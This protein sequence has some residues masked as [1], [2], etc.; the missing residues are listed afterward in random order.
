MINIC[1]QWIILQWLHFGKMYPYSPTGKHL[2][3]W[4][5][6]RSKLPTPRVILDS[7]AR[8]RIGKVLEY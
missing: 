4:F 6:S 2:M 7:P 1:H 5:S 3:K 8:H